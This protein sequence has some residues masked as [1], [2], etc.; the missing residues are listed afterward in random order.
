MLNIQNTYNDMYLR[1]NTGIRIA[2][3]ALKRYIEAAEIKLGPS[4][5]HRQEDGGRM[6]HKTL[7]ALIADFSLFNRNIKLIQSLNN[8][9]I[10]HEEIKNTGGIVHPQHEYYED[11]MKNLIKEL[12]KLHDELYHVVREIHAETIILNR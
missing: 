1:A 12:T 5:N 8:I 7:D 4:E 3:H 10:R 11:I 2:T 6:K 9:R